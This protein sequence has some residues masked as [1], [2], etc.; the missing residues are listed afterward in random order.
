LKLKGIIW[1]KIFIKAGIFLLFFI[2]IIFIIS[3]WNIVTNYQNQF[4]IEKSV[5]NGHPKGISFIAKIFQKIK[6]GKNRLEKVNR[7]TIDSRLKNITLEEMPV[8]QSD[9]ESGNTEEKRISS[10]LSIMTEPLESIKKKF[11][12]FIYEG[13]ISTTLPFFK[14]SFNKKNKT[15]GRKI[16]ISGKFIFKKDRHNNFYLN[17]KT[18]CSE[19]NSKYNSDQYNGILYFVNGKIIYKNHNNPNTFDESNLTILKINYIEPL[20]R[21]ILMQTLEDIKYI[22]GFDKIEDNESVIRYVIK[23]INPEMQKQTVYL[24]HLSGV[25]EILKLENSMLKGKINGDSRFM[26]GFLIG[27]DAKY[28]ITLRIYNIGKVQPITIP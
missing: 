26:E 4:A 17:Q 5:N 18:K 14:R 16:E 19:E 9:K 8:N 12:S 2:F 22:I 6:M 15:P 11:S 1:Q 27:A 10:L 7:S 20:I 28:S 25:I 24:R 3:K 13:E 21:T 23:G